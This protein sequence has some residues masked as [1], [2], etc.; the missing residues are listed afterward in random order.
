[1]A[2]QHNPQPRCVRYDIVGGPD[3][4][5]LMASYGVLGP[6]GLEGRITVMFLL[7]NI[8]PGT[9]IFGF[10][11]GNIK[12]DEPTLPREW[13]VDGLLHEDGSGHSHMVLCNGRDSEGRFRF[14]TGFYSTGRRNGCLIVW[15][16]GIV[17]PSHFALRDE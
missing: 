13:F 5:R 15:D 9:Q 17:P 7:G 1:M 6:D 11:D 12:V 10:R 4:M 3:L 2:P 8:L 16:P 14:A